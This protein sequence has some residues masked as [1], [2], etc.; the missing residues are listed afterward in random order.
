MFHHF[1]LS[2]PFLTHLSGYF[3]TDT[4]TIKK[5]KA[6]GGVLLGRTRETTSVVKCRTTWNYVG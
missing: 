4:K 5:A 1:L 2:H 3:N 6:S